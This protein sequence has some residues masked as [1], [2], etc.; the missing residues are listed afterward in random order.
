MKRKVLS[1][2]FVIFSLDSVGMAA[3]R[4]DRPEE[5]NRHSD[6]QKERKD[7]SRPGHKND[8]D[9]SIHRPTVVKLKPGKHRSAI[10][11]SGF[12]LVLPNHRSPVY[13]AVSVPLGGERIH[14]LP[15]GA[16]K[17][18]SGREDVYIVDNKYHRQYNDGYYQVI[19]P[20]DG[21]EMLD[22]KG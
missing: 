12:S 2:L 11:A 7:S 8:R 9:K 21:M 14:L 1:I 20:F 22:Y 15:S 13:Y 16:K 3:P 5:I 6:I 19:S 18:K 17:M 10:S 4:E